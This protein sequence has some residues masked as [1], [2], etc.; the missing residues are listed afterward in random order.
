E[1]AKGQKYVS[2]Q[3]DP[4]C[5]QYIN[6]IINRQPNISKPELVKIIFHNFQYTPEDKLNRRVCIAFLSRFS[7]KAA[8][9]I[10]AKLIKISSR[11]S[12]DY[13]S[14]FQDLLQIALK[15]AL[16][17][18]KCLDN[19]FQYSEYQDLE[20]KIWYHK[21]EKY[22]T[23]RM[24]GL[25]SDNLREIEGLKTFQRSELGLV[26][27][28]TKTRVI[29]V[30][31]SLGLNQTTI[32]HYTLAWQCFKEVK[33]A[34]LINISSPQPQAFEQISH[35]YHQFYQQ[36]PQLFSNSQTVDGTT[37]KQWLEEIGRAIRNYID[38][39][40]VSLDEPISQDSEK[41][42]W[43]DL[44]PD[45]NSMIQKNDLLSH[46]IA[47][48]VNELRELIN[49]TIEKLSPEDHRIPLL[50]HGLELS[51][52][53]IGTEIGVNQSTVGRRYKKLLLLLLNQLGQWANDYLRI[54]L[55]SE[56]LNE[57]KIYLQEYLNMLYQNLIYR[58]FNN[59]IKT[60]ELPTRK[61]L[62]LFW[63]QQIKLDKIARFLNVSILE[64][65]EIN[66]LLESCNLV[67]KS[68]VIQ[69]IEVKTDMSFAPEGIACNQVG[70]L[71]DEWL[72]TASFIEIY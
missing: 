72:K 10:R 33:D 69:Q 58:F 67:I 27:R 57:L 36:L 16:S 53:K 20:L 44:I 12:L 23:K 31:K 49:H 39:N 60:I 43:L 17:P 71:M 14:T 68:Y 70:F 34:G 29:N 47:E 61:V 13:D 19:L 38:A 9:E 30:L 65:S 22:L 51:Q 42:T 1:D 55:N 40:Q 28:V 32:Q 21:L 63:I 24:Q 62:D 41:L 5:Y 54:D 35:R 2:W 4:K 46:E 3:V 18:E 48:S 25:L 26:A 50:L 66:H 15:N 11:M 8:C 37:I 59:A 64:I 7:Y 52:E 45:E 56:K 6:S